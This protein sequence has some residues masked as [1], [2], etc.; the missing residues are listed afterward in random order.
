MDFRDGG[1]MISSTLLRN[2]KI[3]FGVGVEVRCTNIQC[4][5]PKKLKIENFHFALQKGTNKVL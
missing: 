5:T 4:N 2:L 1:S 3:G